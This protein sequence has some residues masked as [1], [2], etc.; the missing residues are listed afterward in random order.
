MT[1]KKT[2]R[3]DDPDFARPVVSSEYD[4]LD[5]Q[6]TLRRVLQLH[7]K[8]I[9]LIREW[10]NVWAEL[11]QFAGSSSAVYTWSGVAAM[12]AVSRR[13]KPLAATLTT[14]AATG[15]AADIANAAAV[16][17]HVVW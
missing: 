12:C 5:R 3:D 2:R 14:S 1:K 9:E 13:S 4:E 16:A 6:G 8:R 10:Q 17:R 11:H 7:K 15:P